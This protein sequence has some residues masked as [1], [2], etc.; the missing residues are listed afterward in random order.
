MG[1]SLY[2]SE[3]HAGLHG[4][5]QIVREILKVSV[6]FEGMR[7]LRDSKDI[8]DPVIQGSS[9]SLPAS[10]VHLAV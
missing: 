6:Q 2:T 9:A 5:H 4:S 1:R 8:R 10:I 3:T 7:L